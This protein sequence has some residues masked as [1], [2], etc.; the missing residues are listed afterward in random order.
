M[1]RFSA[2]NAIV[3]VNVVLLTALFL[4]LKHHLWDASSGRS[5]GSLF[6]D[7]YD[8]D[9]GYEGGNVHDQDVVQGLNGIHTDDQFR[10]KEGKTLQVNGGAT[11]SLVGLEGVRGRKKKEIKTAVV[12]ASQTSENATWI[13]EAFPQW[14][15]YIYR[16]D[17][18]G[19]KL[20]VPKNKGR[21]SMVYLTYVRSSFGL[22]ITHGERT[23][24]GS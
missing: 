1:P 10:S 23:R 19:A 3:L 8:E 21:E 12:V 7:F 15:Q 14:E 13:A 16:V 20:T 11:S 18:P 6:S 4:H 2:R 24:Y 22:R 5:A 17:D 9:D